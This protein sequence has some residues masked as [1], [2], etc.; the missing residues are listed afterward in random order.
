MPY[1]IR[2]VPPRRCRSGLE[3]LSEI[4]RSLSDDEITEEI[5]HDPYLIVREVKPERPGRRVQ[6]S[7]E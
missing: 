2:S 7:Q 6:Q 1:L 5:L 3:F 4:E